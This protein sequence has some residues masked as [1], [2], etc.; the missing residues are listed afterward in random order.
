MNHLFKKD[1]IYTQKELYEI[2]ELNDLVPTD[3]LKDDNEISV[4]DTED[5]DPIWT[6]R[7]IHNCSDVSLTFYLEWTDEQYL[8][9]NSLLQNFNLN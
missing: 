8:I 7:L 5:G 2:I 6:F 4:S 3:C 1:K 9:K